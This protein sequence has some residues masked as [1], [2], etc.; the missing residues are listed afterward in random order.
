MYQKNG[1]PYGTLTRLEQKFRSIC[2][3]TRAFSYQTKKARFVTNKPVFHKLKASLLS[4]NILIH[5]F[6][7]FIKANELDSGR[8]CQCNN[9]SEFK[10]KEALREEVESTFPVVHALRYTNG[11]CQCHGGLFVL[12]VNP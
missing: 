3:T 4:V 10:V 12:Q 5:F 8:S 2:D 11:L 6:N 9:N 1:L 7:Q